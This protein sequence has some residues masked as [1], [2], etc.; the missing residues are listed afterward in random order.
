M[1][2]AG[3]RRCEVACL[4]PQG[5]HRMRYREW[6]SPDAARVVVCVHGLTRNARDFDPFAGG[7]VAAGYRVVCPD[8]VGRGA[9][10]WLADPAEYGFPRYLAD[11]TVL[12]GR[13]NVVSVDW[14]GTSMGGLIGMMLAAQAG[15][16]VR[17]LVLNDVGPLIPQAALRRI[18]DYVGSDPRFADMAAA[19][20]Y[21]RAVHAPFG[22]L[23]DAA[24][25]DLTEASV[26]PAQDGRGYRLR[27]DP[28]IA[29]A[30]ADLAEGD[31][32]LWSLWDRVAVPTLALRGASSDLLLPA[33][34][35][36]MKRRGP[37]AEV[38]EV[39]GCGHAPALRDAA[40][41]KLILEWLLRE[42]GAP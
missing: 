3:P 16:P 9:S 27:Y 21:I 8:V 37:K 18:A 28:A 23:D 29:A 31:V 13:L 26:T 30:F 25:G 5:F 22:A 4:S 1:T 19:E 35:Q 11:M 40:Q 36:E 32:D 41:T 34:A 10:D 2:A 24:W 17:R 7:L 39:A 15:H 12:L 33:T 20:A 38:V 42:D 6:G 14:V